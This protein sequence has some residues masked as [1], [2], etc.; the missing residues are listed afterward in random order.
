[1]LI[2]V[3]VG[4]V[5]IVITPSGDAETK[6]SK[7]KVKKAAPAPVKK[8]E[9]QTEANMEW[10]PDHVANTHKATTKRRK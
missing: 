5:Y 10:I 2:G 7:P 9:P 6:T 3:V 4:L 1:M 8:E